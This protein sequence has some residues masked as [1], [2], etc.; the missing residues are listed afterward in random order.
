MAA[1]DRFRGK[2]GNPN[3]PSPPLS[4]ATPVLHTA[5]GAGDAQGIGSRVPCVP[6]VDCPNGMGYP[7]ILT[8]QL[9]ILP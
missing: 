7:Q 4:P 2:E 6:F 3:A 1:C 8:R 9:V 5:I